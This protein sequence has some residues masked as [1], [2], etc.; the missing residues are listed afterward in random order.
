MKII[1][2]TKLLSSAVTKVFRAVSS[3]S[4][5]PV[6]EGILICAEDNKIILSGYDLEIGII[7]QIEANVYKKGSVV[8]NAKLLS[9][10]VRS[11]PSNEISISVDEKNIATITSGIS[12]FSISA[13]DSL[14]YPQMPIFNNTDHIIINSGI[15][16][17]MIEQTLF[18]VATNDI[19]P[20]HTGSLMECKDNVL[21][22]VSVDGVKLALKKTQVDYNN[23]QSVVIPGKTL[24]ELSKL[25]TD[26]ETQV[27][28]SV[29]DKHIIFEFSECKVIS[30][31]IEGEFLDYKSS[32]PQNHLTEIIVSPKDLIDSIERTSLII[33][34]KLKAPIKL[35]LEENLIKF[36]CQSP[37]GSSYDELSCHINGNLFEIGFNSKALL[38]ALKVIDNENIK[39]L[40]NGSLSPM[41]I[42]P[43]D[44]EDF[45]FL[46]L[47]VRLK[48]DDKSE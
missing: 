17:N 27:K 9:D 32:I 1:C 40:L 8:L 46:V 10:I 34:D 35:V 43:V 22:L 6:L 41:K 47:P 12:Q 2:D 19:K 3:K 7:T 42:T 23:K 21:T 31:L 20:V 36:F 26:L 30:R 24:S 18:A 5:I 25:I 28:I 44:S 33:S 39:L 14:E 29:S 37:T 16:K 48:S 45:I 11:V 4:T 15:F 13:Q 38:D